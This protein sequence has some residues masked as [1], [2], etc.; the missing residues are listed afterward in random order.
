MRRRSPSSHS[1]R[2]K[3][4]RHSASNTVRN[5][6]CPVVHHQW[7]AFAS[8]TLSLRNHRQKLGRTQL[9]QRW[10]ALV[11]RCR[12]VFTVHL[13]VA[14]K[15][16]QHSRFWPSSAGFLLSKVLKAALLLPCVLNSPNCL[17]TASSVSLSVA[18]LLSKTCAT[19]RQ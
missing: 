17:A 8:T 5:C 1:S 14:S 4:T 16:H 10:L 9:N 3:Q 13:I 19:A 15:R 18:N 2:Q 11:V 12:R 6:V 7:T